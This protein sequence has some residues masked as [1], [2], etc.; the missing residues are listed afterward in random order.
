MDE[1]AARPLRAMSQR[2]S[3]GVRQV[4]PKDPCGLGL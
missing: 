1:G 3:N 2:Y 4:R